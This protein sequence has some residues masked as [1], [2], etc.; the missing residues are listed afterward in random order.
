MLKIYSINDPYIAH[1][2]TIDSKVQN[3]YSEAKPYLGVVCNVGSMNWYAPLTSKKNNQ[4][5]IS[6]GVVWAYKITGR[7]NPPNMLGMLDFRN[8]IPAQ[9]ACLKEFFGTSPLSQFM[10]QTNPLAEITHKRRA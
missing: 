8:L 10:D 3:N 6:S 1:L 7:G 2:K 4:T 9:A 5:D